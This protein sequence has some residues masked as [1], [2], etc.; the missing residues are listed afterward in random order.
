DQVIQHGVTEQELQK[1]KNQ[2]LLN[3]YR[4][5]ETINGKAQLLGNYEV[6][7]G[8]YQQLFDAPAAYQKLTPAEIQAVAAK[9]LKKS[10]RTIGVLA[11][12]ED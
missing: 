2:K 4:L 11:A 6:F 3:L 1:V 7:H 9:Y 8:G 12:K 5:Q 10:Q